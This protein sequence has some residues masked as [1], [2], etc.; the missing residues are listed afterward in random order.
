MSWAKRMRSAFK[1]IGILDVVDGT[2]KKPDASLDPD[3]Y[4]IWTQKDLV[5]QSMILGAIDGS[6]VVKIDDDGSLVGLGTTEYGQTGTGSFMH[7]FRVLTRPLDANGDLSE[8]VKTFQTAIQ[9][10]QKA[11]F[12]IAGPI[13][14][15]IFLT[16]LPADP[17]D[18]ASW[19]A[20]VQSV[21]IDMKKTTLVSVIQ[22]ALDARRKPAGSAD[23]GESALAALEHAAKVR[24]KVFCRNCKREGH[25]AESCYSPGGGKAGQ[26]P[27]QKKRKG[28]GKNKGKEKAHNTDGGG[29][30]DSN[31]VRAPYP[32]EMIDHSR[33]LEE[34]RDHTSSVVR[35]LF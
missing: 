30:E 34:N 8:H 10:L 24:G 25:V 12:I 28:N 20:H 5:A 23:A 22:G 32:G 14:A 13:A 26:G 29:D 33:R 19:H 15:A 21:N 2:L 9:S 11:G 31:H 3:A 7:W 27:R 17:N 18:S 6:L 16:T 35:G 4:A 1:A